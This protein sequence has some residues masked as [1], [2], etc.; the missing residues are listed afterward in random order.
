MG[1]VAGAD[2]ADAFD[3]SPSIQMLRGEQGACGDR[4]MGVDVKISDE[5]HRF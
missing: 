1:E 5:T 4:V 3:P 2:H